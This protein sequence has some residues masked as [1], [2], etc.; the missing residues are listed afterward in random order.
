[1]K[2]FRT[3]SL[4]IS[5]IVAALAGCVLGQAATHANGKTTAKPFECTRRIE[6]SDWKILVAGI[7]TKNPAAAKRLETDVE[8]Q[9]TQIKNLKQLL[10]FACE[11][12]KEDVLNDPVNSAE[13]ENTK[14]EVV[15]T[16]FDKLIKK[17]A[18]QPQ[19][20]S[21][22]PVR[23]AGFYK[24]PAN[25]V[26]F[27]DFLKVKLAL[28]KRSGEGQA[29]TAP[30]KAEIDEARDMFAKMRISEA[31]SRIRATTLDP[32]FWVKTGLTV[33]L[34]QAQ[35]LSRIVSD[36]IAGKTAVSDSEIAKYIAI[37]P[38]FDV[39]KKKEKA[40]KILARAKSGEDF[41]ALANEFTDD[42][43]NTQTDGTKSGGIYRNVPKGMMIGEFEK[44]ALALNPG[45]VSPE[46]VE[47]EFGYHIIKLEKK[48]EVKKPDGTTGF[49]YDVR[50]ILISTG[51]KD[52]ENP[53]AHDV[54]VKDFVRD[55]LETEKERLM[56]D[57]LV[58]DN[59]IVIAAFPAAGETVA[60]PPL[61]KRPVRRSH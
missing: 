34:Q 18:G 37:H 50:H 28:I 42:P 30:T 55:K 41:A 13:L 32:A 25:E 47:T 27:S 12:V 10:A 35:F 2:R 33:K 51:Y 48:G 40:A 6:T 61:R 20:S 46:L 29:A 7:K 17:A 15:A 57:K 39:S 43:G 19:F 38:E 45:K 16:E 53:S 3:N 54:P 59:M 24:I 22:G 21:I 52:P 9:N 26:K 44:A 58:K 49:Q 1:M 31:D 23:V 4:V 56:V 8:F 11:A 60:K 36:I 5:G 14:L